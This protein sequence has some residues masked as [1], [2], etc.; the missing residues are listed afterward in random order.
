M[1]WNNTE[2]WA[3]RD[4]IQNRAFLTFVERGVEED[5]PPPGGSAGGKKKKEQMTDLQSLLTTP[6][7]VKSLAVPTL[8]G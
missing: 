8:Q 5:E 6:S 7:P 1:L 4:I 3:K 2:S